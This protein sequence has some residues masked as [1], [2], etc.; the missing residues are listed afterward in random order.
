M[1]LLGTRQLLFKFVSFKLIFLK[2]LR[3]AFLNNAGTPREIVA[4]LHAALVKGI[5]DKA[6]TARLLS[7]GMEPVLN[8]PEQFA[9][10]I[11]QDLPRWGKLVK[12]AGIKP[13]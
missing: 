6:V 7:Q 10:R 13:Q 11:K 2:S 5:G 4:R 9:E 12:A 3:T 8:T 1:E